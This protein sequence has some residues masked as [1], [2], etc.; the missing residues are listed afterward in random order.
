[1]SWLKQGPIELVAG[2]TNSCTRHGLSARWALLRGIATLSSEG[3]DLAECSGRISFVTSRGGRRRLLRQKTAKKLRVDVVKMGS[4]VV[5]VSMMHSMKLLLCWAGSWLRVDAIQRWRGC[6]HSWASSRASGVAK[7]NLLRS[8]QI[9]S[10]KP[11][12]MKW[13]WGWAGQRASE[14]GLRG[15]WR[16]RHNLPGPC[17]WTGRRVLGNSKEGQL[18]RSSSLSF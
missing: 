16:R 11:L 8:C 3:G 4:T 9:E 12:R 2:S 6:L 10:P 14:R 18:C 1:M 7:K 17:I 13:Q 15:R 5:V